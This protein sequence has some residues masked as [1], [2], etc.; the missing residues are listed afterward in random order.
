MLGLGAD[1]FSARWLRYL[2]VPVAR[3]Y[4]FT[5]G[6]DDGVRVYID[7]ELVLDEWREQSATLYSFTKYLS[8]GQHLVKVE[9]YESEGKAVA[10]FRWSADAPPA[11]AHWLGEYFNNVELSGAPSLSREDKDIAFHWDF[12]ASSPAPD[13]IAPDNFSVRWTRTLNLSA[14]SYRFIVKA[15][16]GVRLWVNHRLLIDQWHDQAIATY[17]GDIALP[18]GDVPV[19]LEFYEHTGGAHIELSWHPIDASPTYWLGEYYNNR[20]LSG[21]PALVRADADLNFDWEYDTPASDLV[22]SDDFSARWTRTLN[23]PAGNYRFWVASDDGVRVWVNNY[24]LINQWHEHPVRSYTG[25]IYLPGGAV[26]VRVEYYEKSGEAVI[27]L[28]W[29]LIKEP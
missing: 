3:V 6:F 15:D 14:G 23:L 27:R 21:T 26:P 20:T 24:L 5:A 7:D 28:G 22:N 4:F 11:V 29:E 9:Y 18:G 12:A 10:K 25:D 16:D 8:A 13:L 1:E 2:H 17:A 19:K